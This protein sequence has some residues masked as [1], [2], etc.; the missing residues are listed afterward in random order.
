MPDMKPCAQYRLAIATQ[1]LQCFL[2]PI[3]LDTLRLSLG[4]HPL[5]IP[6]EH[7][8]GYYKTWFGCTAVTSH[9]ALRMPVIFDTKILVLVY[10]VPGLVKLVRAP[11][12]L[13]RHYLFGV[14][15]TFVHSCDT[16]F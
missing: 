5:A 12:P 4:F 6:W 15:P 10:N 2:L 3:R 11:F 13:K 9:H 14:K 7:K 16:L 1:Y 8:A